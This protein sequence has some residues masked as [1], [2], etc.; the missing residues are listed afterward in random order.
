VDRAIGL[1]V[2]LHQTTALEP[3]ISVDERKVMVMMISQLLK[4]LRP[5]CA[6]YHVR[7][8]NLIW[9]L[10]ALTKRSHVESILAKTMTSQESYNVQ[11][12]YEAFGVLWRLTGQCLDSFLP[13]Q[14]LNPSNK[15]TLFFLA[16]VLRSL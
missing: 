12:A 9:A 7:A 1:V 11:E 13:E 2:A 4:Y 16:F 3:N 8:V 10:D 6:V 14:C 15:R 5:D